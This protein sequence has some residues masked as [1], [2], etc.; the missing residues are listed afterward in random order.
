MENWVAIILTLGFVCAI[1]FLMFGV[2]LT[3]YYERDSTDASGLSENET[4][5]LTT[6]FSGM[7]GIISSYVAYRAGSN[8]QANKRMEEEEQNA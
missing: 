3:A 1:N 4:Q 8:N 5:I 7:I 2:L 6:V